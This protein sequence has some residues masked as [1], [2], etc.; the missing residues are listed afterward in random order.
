M[1]GEGWGQVKPKVIYN[2]GDVSGLVCRIHWLSWGGK[3]AVGIGTGWF[4]TP[5]QI[6]DDGKWEPAVVVLY[7][8]GTWRGRP[9]Y[10]QWDEYFPGDGKGF[11]RV[12]PC[13]A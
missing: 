13:S 3:F 5:G 6:T 12:K 7:P 11:G 10:E 9:A 8:L 2:G 4:L 1:Y